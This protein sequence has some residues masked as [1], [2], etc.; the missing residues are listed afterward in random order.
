MLMTRVASCPISCLMHIFGSLVGVTENRSDRWAGE[1]RTG[2]ELIKEADVCLLNV[3]SVHGHT[4]GCTGS[5]LSQHER[6]LI[7]YLS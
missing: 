7:S 5:A 2:T 4:D 1:E 6:V 3:P